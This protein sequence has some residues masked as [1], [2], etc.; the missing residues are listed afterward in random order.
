M[1]RKFK[2]ISPR[3]QS[4][5]SIQPNYL[6]KNAG[7]LTA[8]SSTYSERASAYFM[9]RLS[10]HRI[11]ERLT[12]RARSRNEV[13]RPGVSFAKVRQCAIKSDRTV[14][15]TKGR[16]RLQTIP[17]TQNRHRSIFIGTISPI[18]R[19]VFHAISVSRL[20]PRAPL[21]PDFRTRITNKTD[22][23]KAVAYRCFE[24]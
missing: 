7:C 15:L 5:S 12:K 24:Q 9:G 14:A 17:H 4:R 1:H 10:K 2:I 11:V 16:K 20:L 19:N 13:S 18:K 21:S 6:S 8:S 23:K 3:K 22:G